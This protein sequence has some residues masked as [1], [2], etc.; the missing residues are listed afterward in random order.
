VK[1]TCIIVTVNRQHY[2]LQQRENPVFGDWFVLVGREP[3][4]NF[5]FKIL[6]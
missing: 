2:E 6:V 1:K 4:P 3:L 5:F